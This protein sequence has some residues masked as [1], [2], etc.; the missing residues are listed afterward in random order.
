MTLPLAQGFPDWQRNIPASN[1]LYLATGLVTDAPRTYGPFWVGYT[2]CIGVHDIVT[3]NGETITFQFADANPA[4]HV[5]GNQQYVIPNGGTLDLSFRALGPW[6]SIIVQPGAATVTHNLT[7][8]ATE[9]PGIN[10]P[11]VAGHVLIAQANV[12]LAAG[13]TANY[14]TTQVWPGE[15][16][17]SVQQ[18]AGTWNGA[19][20]VLSSAGVLTQIDHYNSALQQGFRDLVHLP[21]SLI[22]VTINNTAAAAENHDVFILGRNSAN[23]Y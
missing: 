12:S 14:T 3:A 6:M 9:L 23:Q 2:P 22:T 17:V 8:Y 21:P 15:A 10:C 16:F 7:V 13:G 4:T 18:T 1:V 20:Q 19:L 11:G 5:T